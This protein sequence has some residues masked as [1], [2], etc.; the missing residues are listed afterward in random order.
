MAKKAKEFLAAL[1]GNVAAWYANRIDHET[2][3]VRQR[4]IWDSIRGAG[5]A[6]EE[7]VLTGLREQLAAPRR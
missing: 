1:N 2:F 3:S 7:L 4:V 5:T 6:V